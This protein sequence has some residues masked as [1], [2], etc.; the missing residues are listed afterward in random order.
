MGGFSYL[1][2]GKR[3]GFTCASNG[4]VQPVERTEG[5]GD[6]EVTDFVSTHPHGSTHKIL[7]LGVPMLRSIR[8]TFVLFFGKT[9][10]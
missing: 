9:H 7:T 1:Q 6:E 10:K 4:T 8:G 5:G 3:A 2:G